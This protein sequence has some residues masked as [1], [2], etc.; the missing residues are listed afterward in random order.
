MPAGRR[1][2][3]AGGFGLFYLI[4]MFTAQGYEHLK[5]VGPLAA[6][7]GYQLVPAVTQMLMLGPLPPPPWSSIG[8]DNGRNP[9]RLLSGA[10]RGHSDDAFAGQVPRL[11][12]FAFSPL[13]LRVLSSCRSGGLGSCARGGHEA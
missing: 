13:S 1:W 10:A 5:L 2:A 4:V 8:R 6:T 11:W 9:I 12:R 7:A 3:R